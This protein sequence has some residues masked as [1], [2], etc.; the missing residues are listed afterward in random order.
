MYLQGTYSYLTG[1]LQILCSLFATHGNCTQ[2]KNHSSRVRPGAAGLGRACICRRQV[3]WLRLVSNVF[4]LRAWPWPCQLAHWVETILC[5]SDQFV[6]LSFIFVVPVSAK[7]TLA[8]C[9]RLTHFPRHPIYQC[10]LAQSECNGAAIK[11][12]EVAHWPEIYFGNIEIGGAGGMQWYNLPLTSTS[13][14]CADT[15]HLQRHLSLKSTPTKCF[16][17]AV[18]KSTFASRLWYA[19]ACLA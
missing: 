5:L 6:E 7:K 16:Q 14:F 1:P 3:V 18:T 2:P 4:R 12:L 17:L 9:F 19:V 13:V 8:D 10:W 15:R 11:K